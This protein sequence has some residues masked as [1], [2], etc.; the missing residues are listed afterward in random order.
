[1]AHRVSLEALVGVSR[2]AILALDGRGLVRNVLAATRVGPCRVWAVGKAAPAMAEGARDAL[3]DDLASGLIISKDPIAPPDAR[4]SV[5]VGAH[6]VP[7]ARSDAAGRALLD[8]A[9]AVGEEERVILLLSGG[10]SA[11]VSSP[12]DGVTLDEMREITQALVRSG[13]P[14]GDINTVRRHLGRVLGGKLAA[15]CRGRILALALSDV[16]GSDPAAIGSGPV[17]PDATTVADAVAVAAQRMLADRHIDAIARAPETPKPG[18]ACFERVDHR[19]LAGPEALRDVAVHEVEAA[20][21]RAVVR[22]ALV[23]RE[24][25]AFADELTAAFE[26][27]AAGDVLVAV[28]EP[29]LRVT[30]AGRGGRAQH[31]A[32]FIARALAGRPMAFV[33]CGSDGSDGPTDAAG[34]FVDGDTWDA[35]VARGLRPADALAAFDAHTLLAAASA[36]LVTGPTGTNVC[37]LFLLGRRA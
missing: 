27:L 26:T 32:L 8:A 36:T 37:D 34:A 6:P 2:R 17:S 20:G 15:A 24:L 23:A 18:D 4:F 25:Y 3:G 16:I 29:T 35:A 12:V 22:R 33:A 10:T 7:D 1:M 19:V 11:L 14:I 21:F 5:I 31:L 13:A 28:G 30:G 9:R